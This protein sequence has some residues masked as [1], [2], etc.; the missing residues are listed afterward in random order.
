MTQTAI[1]YANELFKTGITR[2]ILSDAK[3]ILDAVPQIRLEFEDPTVELEKKHTVIEKVFPVEIRNFLKLLCDN[4]DFGL[5]DGIYQEYKNLGKTKETIET[6]AD[7]YYVTPPTEKQLEGIRKFLAKQFNN[8]DIEIITIKDESLKS[9]FVLRIGNKEYDWSE[10][11][12]IEQ[13]QKVVEK[14]VSEEKNSADADSISTENIISIL[15]SNIY[16]FDLEAKDKEIGVV[17]WVGDGIANVDGIDHAFYGEI[18]V[19]DS[20]VKGMVQDVRKE[21][22]QD[23]R[24][25][26]WR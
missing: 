16:D 20:G 24:Y 8:E 13:L 14:A 23:G 1:N 15:R 19:F 11:G 2:E 22:R 4:G 5:F 21:Y 26:C 9:G 3:D 10:K 6:Q 12:R 17:N 25:L 18:V 7:L